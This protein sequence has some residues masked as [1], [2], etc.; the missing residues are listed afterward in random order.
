MRS[1]NPAPAGT[2][3]IETDIPVNT[4]KIKGSM[5]KTSRNMI[6][7]PIEMNPIVIRPPLKMK[8]SLFDLIRTISA[9]VVRKE[10]HTLR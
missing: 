8:P 1:Y 3:M 5:L 4:I 10:L 2:T 7:R 9:L 6:D